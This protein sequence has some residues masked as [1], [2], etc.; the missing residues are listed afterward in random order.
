MSVTY[1]SGSYTYDSGVLTYNGG[2]VLITRTATGSGSGTSTTVGVIVR[3]RFSSSSATGSGTANYRREFFRGATGSGLGSS[4]TVSNK[5]LFRTAT[6]SG[7][8]TEAT[9][10]GRFFQRTGTGSGSST[11]TATPN[12]LFI[13]RPP[14]NDSFS[15]ADRNNPVAGDFLLRKL[16]PGVRAKNVYK[17]TDGTF[18]TN[19]P[20]EVEDYTIVY[21]GAHN[22]IVSAE[23]KADLVSAGYGAYV[24]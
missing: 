12:K 23:E 22:N 8:G 19:Q 9:V 16:V 6:G 24:T 5:V 4:S 11:Q 7:A 3:S 18:T 14:V 15:W 21:L 2:S 10:S 1:D 17:L 13:F 20:A